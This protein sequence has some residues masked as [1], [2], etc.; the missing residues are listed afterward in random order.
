MSS[1]WRTPGLSD[2][3]SSVTVDEH[4]LDE[5]VVVLLQGKNEFRQGLY[6]YVKLAL[7]QLEKMHDV[8]VSGKKF[9]PSDFGE[10][11]A[12]GVGYPNEELRSEMAVKYNMMDVPEPKGPTIPPQPTVWSEHDE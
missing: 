10:V 1:N 5:E 6:A 3:A 11:L 2:N 12:A 4:L 9:M 8:M 7:R